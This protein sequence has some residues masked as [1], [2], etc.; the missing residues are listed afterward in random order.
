MGWWEIIKIIRFQIKQYAIFSSFCHKIQGN[1][2]ILE[3]LPPWN[4]IDLAWSSSSNFQL[5]ICRFEILFHGGIFLEIWKKL[6]QFFYYHLRLHLYPNFQK[7]CRWISWSS[8]SASGLRRQGDFFLER[9]DSNPTVSL[10]FFS[11]VVF[12]Y[13][14]IFV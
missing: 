11:Q 6:I 9:I 7:G 1:P 2:R 12:I 5:K 10:F 3:K 13:V 4:K 8:G 14:L